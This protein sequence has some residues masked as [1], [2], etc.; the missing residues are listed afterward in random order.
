MKPGALPLPPSMDLPQSEHRLTVTPPIAN[1]TG[2]VVDFATTSAR[3]L[4]SSRRRS[5]P[6]LL[7]V[8]HKDDG[9]RSEADDVGP[10]N[11]RRHLSFNLIVRLLQ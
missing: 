3:V 7:R 4:L 5:P 1:N 9:R 8:I 6:P 10:A 11:L 2:V